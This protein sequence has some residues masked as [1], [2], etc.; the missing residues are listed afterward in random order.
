MRFNLVLEGDVICGHRHGL[1]LTS[2]VNTHSNN[3]KSERFVSNYFEILKKLEHCL[4][5]VIICFI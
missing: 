2:F 1:T 4:Y 5:I 3:I